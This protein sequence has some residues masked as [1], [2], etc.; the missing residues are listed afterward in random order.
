MIV[1]RFELTEK[2]VDKTMSTV[3][4]LAELDLW[5]SSFFTRRM[6]LELQELLT[7]ACASNLLLRPSPIVPEQ[8]KRRLAEAFRQ[9]ELVALPLGA[10]RLKRSGGPGTNS[11]SAPAPQPVIPLLADQSGEKKGKEKAQK[12]KAQKEEQKKETKQ[13]LT[14][15]SFQLVD[16]DG[17]PMG[18]VQYRLTLP[19][20]G[21][22]EG[23]LD[24][25]GFLQVDGITA[26]QCKLSFP[27][28]EAKSGAATN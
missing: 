21:V 1:R 20:G 27:D 4:V 11:P 15:V 23:K 13:E 5:L 3:F 8:F 16:E 2:E 14:W 22:R 25:G 24:S 6:C 10:V 9:G 19:D 28:L 18:G 7:G 12:E 17:K 26:G